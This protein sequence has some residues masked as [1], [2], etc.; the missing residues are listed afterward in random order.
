MSNSISPISGINGIDISAAQRQVDFNKIAQW[1]KFVIIKGTEGIGFQDS[2]HK[3]HTANAKAAG[4]LTTSYHFARFNSDPNNQ[5]DWFM[6]NLINPELPPVLDV[7]FDSEKGCPG[8]D[9]Q[10]SAISRNFVAQWTETFISRFVSKMGYYPML[11]TSPG[12]ANNVPFKSDG[13]AAKCPLWIS[14]YGVWRDGSKP[15]KCSVWGNEFAIWQYAGN[16]VKDNTGRVIANPGRVDGF[17]GEI[18][19]NVFTGTEDDLKNMIENNKVSNPMSFFDYKP[20]EWGLRT[21]EQV[22]R[23]LFPNG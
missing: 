11:Y 1:G 17:N 13:I 16:T 8:W 4:L 10:T 5:C 6:S 7:E 2:F 15:S 9:G 3:Q 20:Q 22:L 19:V 21:A 18:D 14:H 23:E 12:Y